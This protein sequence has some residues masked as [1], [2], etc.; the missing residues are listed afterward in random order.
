MNVESLTSRF[1]VLI[2]DDELG[3]RDL[4]LEYFQS[5][6]FDAV[7]ASDGRQAMTLLQASNGSFGL[8]VTDLSLPGADGF[9]VL[10]AARHAN[11]QAYVVIVTGYASLESAIKAVRS[12]AYDYLAKPFSLSQ[13]EVL[14]GR[15]QDRIELEES[16]RRL[17]FERSVADY[18]GRH[19]SDGVERRLAGIEASLT[20]IEQS[21][22][23]RA[24]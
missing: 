7:A 4:L 23:R 18:P 6:G 11:A 20:R 19:T 1:K 5:L 22:A 21:L 15:I 14:L 9:A 12:G 17:R 8:V 16:S 2:V 13:V 10:H 24:F 3:A